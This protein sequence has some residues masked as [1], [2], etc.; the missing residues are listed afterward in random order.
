[1]LPDL[2][3]PRGQE[4]KRDVLKLMH[5]SE[6]DLIR[7]VIEN[8]LSIGT[9]D[10]IVFEIGNEPNIY[11]AM[12]PE[13]YGWYLEMYADTIKKAAAAVRSQQKRVVN[14]KI[15]AAGLWISDGMPSALV[16]ALNQGLHIS[17]GVLSIAVPVGIDICKWL[18]IP[19]PCG[20][21]WRGIQLNEGMD[22]KSQFYT[23]VRSYW[24]KTLAASGKGTIDIA[25]LHFYPYIATGA[26][27]SMQQQ[28][29]NL[30]TLAAHA[31]D[32]ATTHDVW[33]TEIGNFNPYTDI[34]ATAKVM[35]PML[36]ALKANFVPYAKRWYWFK[37]AGDDKKFKSLPGQWVYDLA[38]GWAVLIEIIESVASPA[39]ILGEAVTVKKPKLGPQ[40]VKELLRF[41]GRIKGNNPA[42][43]LYESESAMAA[44]NPRQLGIVYR[45]FAL[46]STHIARR[47]RGRYE[48]VSERDYIDE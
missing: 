32:G 43:G 7:K 28:L 27:L 31:A 25:N 21:L 3:V 22:I 48:G 42:Q 4:Y 36:T 41:L 8:Y 14:V 13:T 10:T 11:P 33:L 1:M 19:Y 46:N 23:D 45:S 29:V 44:G 34:N 38:G 5:D 30:K 12:A 35:K 26:T 16:E 47:L 2:G 20:V 9:S 24:D 18:G 40:A 17:F 39:S 15:M 37:N 6:K